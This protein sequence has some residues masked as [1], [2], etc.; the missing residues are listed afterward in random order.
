MS[1][2]G[3]T[4]PGDGIDGTPTNIGVG[5]Q[6]F[7]MVAGEETTLKV[8]LLDDQ[9]SVV[10]YS[11]LRMFTWS[12]N[13]PTVATVSNAGVVRIPPTATAFGMATI[14]VSFQDLY[15]ETQVVVGP[16]G[17]ALHVRPSQLTLT[18]GGRIVLQGLVETASGDRYSQYLLQFSLDG[19]GAHLTEQG[20]AITDCV[21][22]E[23]DEAILFGDSP[24]NATVHVT[25]GSGSTTV[26]VTVRFATFTS[27]TAGSGHSCG[28][29]AGGALFCWGGSL[30]RTPVGVDYPAGLTDIQAG[31]TQTCGLDPAG[32][33]YCWRD[34][35][36]ATASP[37][38][39]TLHFS[40]LALMESF[41]C[42]LDLSGAAWCW[43]ENDWG[44][45]GDGSQTPSA[46]PVA[47]TGG[48]TFT[49]M[50]AGGKHACGITAG[51]AAYCWGMNFAG[52]LGT[53]A[54]MPDLCPPYSC[55]PAPLPV[56]G[57]HS[58]SQIVAGDNHTCALD[59][60][61][62]AWCW[63]FSD[64]RGAGPGSDTSPPA[65]PTPIAVA[66]GL[67][68]AHLTGGPKHTCGLTSSGQAYCWGTNGDGRTGQTPS[69]PIGFD[70][71]AI[72]LSPTLVQGGHSFSQLDAG[73]A[74][75]CGLAGDGVYCWGDNGNGQIGIFQGNTQLP[76]RV[77]GQP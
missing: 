68:F 58:F 31:V 14:R 6:N 48:L 37:I 50:T 33:A 15:A 42:G 24:G 66:G 10:P 76:V 27:V 30:A 54:S 38:S 72:V 29:E 21:G 18:P 61:G 5:P 12:S 40:K 65:S 62:A 55:S 16:P 4:D 1:C 52:E 63:G 45:L 75:T 28:L 64:K 67:V 26:P 56:D 3:G 11:S 20:C 46:D 25:G 2:G 49:A 77:T 19:S 39:T 41:S 43:G 9:G 57:G 34:T 69:P 44:Q 47:V 36:N 71:S 22:A 8:V 59:T 53:T 73:G 17:V 60:A 23:P 13:A 74:H 70:G 51:G 32:L 7:A 35:L